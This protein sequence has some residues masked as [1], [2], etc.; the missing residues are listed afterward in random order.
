MTLE[1]IKLYA[2]NTTTLG[3]TTFMPFEEG[4]KIVL[5]LVTIGY[6]ISK[7]IGIKKKNKK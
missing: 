7:W 2:L 6:T 5:L 1:D 3:A 4:L